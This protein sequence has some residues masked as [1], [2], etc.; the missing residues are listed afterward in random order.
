[1][2][3]RFFGGRSIAAFLAD[4]S[5]K[6]KKSGQGV[7]LVGTGFGDAEADREEE[8]KEKERLHKYAEWLEQD[9]GEQ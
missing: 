8:E 3:G 6:Y 5:K 1:M 4:G 9:K 2:N 7:D